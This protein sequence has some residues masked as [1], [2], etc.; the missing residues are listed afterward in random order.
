[1]GKCF[2][3]KISIKVYEGISR[4]VATYKVV[5]YKNVPLGVKIKCFLQKI[6]MGFN[7][8][9]VIYEDHMVIV[10]NNT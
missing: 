6:V 8:G 9:G 2:G 7:I 5:L 10:R 1:M 3:A 4:I